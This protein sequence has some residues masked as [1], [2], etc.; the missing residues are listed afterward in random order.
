[1]FLLTCW[2]QILMGKLFAVKLQ[3]YLVYQFL[4]RKLCMKIKMFVMDIF[5]GLTRNKQ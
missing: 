5:N 2:K 3:M 1:M 4:Q